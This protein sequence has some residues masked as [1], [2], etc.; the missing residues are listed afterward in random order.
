[1]NEKVE[2][3]RTLT[4]F[5]TKIGSSVMATIDGMLSPQAIEKLQKLMKETNMF[6]T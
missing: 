1:M 2:L 3:L 5:G 4:Q 6:L